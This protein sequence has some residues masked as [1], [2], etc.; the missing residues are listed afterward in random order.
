VNIFN[1][2]KF[3]LGGL[4][5]LGIFAV[6]LTNIDESMSSISQT[7]YGISD[8]AQTGTWAIYPLAPTT[9]WDKTDE[10]TPDGDGTYIQNI[11]STASLW[12]NISPFTFSTSLPL[13]NIVVTV[14]IL[15]EVSGDP[16]STYYA[17]PGVIMNGTYST[18][19]AYLYID[20]TSEYA[21]YT[22]T[23][24]YDLSGG[25]SQAWTAALINSDLGSI[26]VRVKP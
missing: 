10:V 19:V 5:I 9:Y 8:N 7:R 12:C 13:E 11:S 4:L 18:E 1:A 23:I 24:P 22:A 26:G 17:L 25:I 6:I 15:C 2:I 3:L 20:G 16:G 21:E 14:H